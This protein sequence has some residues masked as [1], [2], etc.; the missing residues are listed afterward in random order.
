MLTALLQ[1]C[2]CGF[3]HDLDLSYGDITTPAMNNKRSWVT[4]KHINH[5]CAHTPECRFLQNLFP[6]LFPPNGVKCSVQI[7]YHFNKIDNKLQLKHLLM[8]FYYYIPFIYTLIE[9][10]LHTCKFMCFYIFHLHLRN[11]FICQCRRKE[12]KVNN[13]TLGNLE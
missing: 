6:S 2:A 9:V 1:F 12:V 11:F 5:L 7:D 8:E 13:T 3:S 4:F 10:H